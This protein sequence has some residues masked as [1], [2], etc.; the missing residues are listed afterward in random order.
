MS[1]QTA[2]RTILALGVLSASSLT[3][4]VPEATAFG[5]IRNDAACDNPAVLRAITH[6]FTIND[7]NVIQRDL[8][9]ED[10]YDVYQDKFVA[11]SEVEGT[12]IDRRFCRGKV[13]MNDGRTRTIW[14]MIEL[15][16]GFAGVGAN[17]EYCISGLDPWHIYGAFCRSVR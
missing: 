14:Y 7:R 8:A 13:V 17:V 11:A 4:A 10:Y 16:Q 5:G 3:V 6:R 9:I 1:L 2:V 12:M 15:G